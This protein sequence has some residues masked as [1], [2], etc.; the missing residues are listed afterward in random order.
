MIADALERKD[1]TRA[2]LSRALAQ[3]YALAGRR[4]RRRAGGSAAQRALGRSANMLRCASASAAASFEGTRSG[5]RERSSA[6]GDAGAPPTAV[7]G[8][9]SIDA[10]RCFARA[11]ELSEKLGDVATRRRAAVSS[12]GTTREASWSRAC[13]GPACGRYRRQQRRPRRAHARPVDARRDVDVAGEFAAARRE[14]ELRSRSITRRALPEDVGGR[15]T[16]AST[17][18]RPSW[19]LDRRRQRRRVAASLRCGAALAPRA[20]L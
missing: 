14:L 11:L 18:W 16:P 6:A 12:R 15:S 1:S 19:V 3:H 7:H 8:F 9:A 5:E 20:A 13:P 10:E 4:C 2:T 17:R